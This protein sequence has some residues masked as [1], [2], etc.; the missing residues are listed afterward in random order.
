MT[1]PPIGLTHYLILAALL[2]GMG[3][4]TVITRRHVIGVLLG[5][6]LM[7]NAANI[8]LVAFARYGGLVPGGL[9]AAT[10]RLALNAHVF[11]LM[12]I[13]LAACEAAVGLAIV[14]RMY[15]TMT[16]TNPD[17]AREMRW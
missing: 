4:F 15:Q 14:L 13:A 8:N 3:L 7:L 2:F 9:G 1:I 5:V 17:E 10:G 11:V 12:V 6:E 16:T